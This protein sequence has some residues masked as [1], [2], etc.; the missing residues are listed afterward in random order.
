VGDPF[1]EARVAPRA[2]TSPDRSALLRRL[3]ESDDRDVAWFLA[4]DRVPDRPDARRARLASWDGTTATVEH[5]G[6][7]DLVIGRTFDPGWLARVD[8]KSEQP[9]FRADAGFLAVRLDGAGIRRVSLR[10]RTPRLALWIAISSG[11]A[12][13]EAA[14][15]AALLLGRVHRY[16]AGNIRS[17][18]DVSLP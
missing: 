13:V 12:I 17:S 10:Y 15:A 1:P 8:D 16:R 5:D 14:I 11:A 9:A 2:R 7:C 4:E 18:R 6:P 3:F